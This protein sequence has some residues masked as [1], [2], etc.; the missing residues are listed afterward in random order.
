MSNSE[1]HDYL[2]E[3]GRHPVLC[4]EAQLRHCQRIYAWVHHE[5]GREGAPSAVRRSGRRSMDVMIRTNTRLVVSIAKRY[6]GRGLDLPDLIQEGNLGLI[7]GLELFDPTRGYAVS[8]Y[9]YWWIRQAITRALHSYARTIRL[10]INTHELLGRIHRFTMETKALTGRAPSLT[11]IAEHV[12][13]TEARVVEVLDHSTVTVCASLDVMCR[14]GESALITL[15]ADENQP[16]SLDE[17]HTAQNYEVIRAAI[18]Q[19]LTET[20]AQILHGIFFDHSTFRAISEEIGCSRARVGQIHHAAL[21][22]LRLHLARQGHT[23]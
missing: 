17:L 8:T 2:T 5:A 14:D 20:E 6:Q 13:T 23:A 11:E 21:N 3:V 10:P 22:K 12:H 9:C 7:R 15:I 19:V 1:I 16:E 4:K 18:Q